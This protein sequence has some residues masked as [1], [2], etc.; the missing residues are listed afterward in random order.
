MDIG[1]LSY[2]DTIGY[3]YNADKYNYQSSTNY[4]M[5]I[6]ILKSGKP[7]GGKGSPLCGVH[8]RLAQKKKSK[9]DSHDDNIITPQL[10][11]SSDIS[12][13]YTTMCQHQDSTA[14]GAPVSAPTTK[15]LD[16]FEAIFD[17]KTGGPNLDGLKTIEGSFYERFDDNKLAFCINN[18]TEIESHFR[19]EAQNSLPLSKYYHA[20]AAGLGECYV[21]YRQVG[22]PGRYYALESISAQNMVREVRHTIFNDYYVDMDIDN[23]H[24]VFTVWLCNKLSIPCYVMADYVR[25]R[26][27]HMK[28]LMVANNI[29]RGQAKQIYLSINYG[30]KRD[31]NLVKHKTQHL[32]DY[33]K[34][35]A[36]IQKAI[37]EKLTYF[38]AYTQKDRAAKGKSYNIAGTCLSHVCAFIENQVLA[39]I[40]EYLL[41]QI[42][43]DAVHHSVL[44]FDGVMIPK[45]SHEDRF[46]PELEALF[47]AMGLPIKLSMKKFEPL[48][49]G[50]MGYD[51]TVMYEV[52][53]PIDEKKKKTKKNQSASEVFDEIFSSSLI[54]NDITLLLG[55][56]DRTWDNFK[57]AMTDSSFRFDELS[58]WAA[59]HCH[60]RN[61]ASND[62]SLSYV[63][64]EK[65]L[66]QIVFD[67]N[68]HYRFVCYFI[69]EFFVFGVQSSHCWIR[70]RVSAH[71]LVPLRPYQ[72]SEFKNVSIQYLITVGE[73]KK[74]AHTEL[75]NLLKVLPCHK[76]S[77]QCHL[78]SH[79]PLDSETFSTAMP[80]QY[81]DLGEVAESDLPDLLLYYLKDVICDG[82][83]ES[84]I[85]LRSYLANIIHQPDQR[86][87]VMT[88]LYSQ[89]KRVGKSTMKWILDLICGVESNIV[90]VERLSDV[91]GERG[92]TTVVGKRIVWFEELTDNKTVFRANMDRMKTALTDKRTTYK[93]LYQELHETNNTNEYLACTNHL[94]G[95]LEDRQTFLHVS[96]RHKDDHEFYGKL[97]RSMDQHGCN[98]FAT[99]LK[100]FTT[101][102]PM[103]CHKTAIYYSM[104]SNSAE[105]IDIFIGDLKSG[106]CPIH[107]SKTPKFWHCSSELLYSKTYHNWCETNNERM[108]T[109]TH[110]KEKLSHYDSDCVYKKCRIGGNL[111]RAFVFP[112]DWIK[113]SDE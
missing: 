73:F 100:P 106:Q 45:G 32:N 63:D 83:E 8:T 12:D 69:H 97:R 76:F 86:T 24:P 88:V 35:A 33:F 5:C 71:N 58:Y 75:F 6:I 96:D 99:Y 48:D 109:L 23:A 30:G 72:I 77:N 26:D 52:E 61:Y 79:D 50:T 110:F 107:L 38:S 67:N 11:T 64:F 25:N 112:V 101:A 13:S 87:E 43:Y 60:I 1:L 103:K 29:T 18:Q 104:L 68:Y 4:I 92:G 28:E 90:K 91:F 74:T 39:R 47:S 57:E 17:I 59:K 3:Q 22:F 81:T 78:W 66:K 7:C 19:P 113:L 20:A 36:A 82:D 102:L 15:P 21:E 40:V 89:K 98:L 111:V 2:I 10:S 65:L 108:L 42:G 95:V 84:W 54:V 27:A 9:S 41:D 56:M 16:L 53:R 34:E 51:S 37:F 14:I 94:V 31:Y 55:G 46:L 93:P 49:L 85:W 80:F 44:C 105:S 62:F 70:S